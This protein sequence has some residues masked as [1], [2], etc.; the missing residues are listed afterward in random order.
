MV[1]YDTWS[2]S[3]GKWSTT[4]PP[5]SVTD[6]DGFDYMFEFNSSRKIK[7]VR[8]SKFDY[9]REYGDEIWEKSR[10]VE[11]AQ[12]PKS[13]YERSTSTSYSLTDRP[14]TGKGLT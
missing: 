7:D 11:M 2:D 5:G 3:A 9:Y 4:K 10:S 12:N 14:W 1:Y 6:V 13:Y 8:V